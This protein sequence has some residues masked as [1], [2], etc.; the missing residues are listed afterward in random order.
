MGQFE[1]TLF[2]YFE[3]M[4]HYVRSLPINLG[5]VT[6]SGG[7]V[8]GPPGGFIGYLPQTRIAYDL[9]E[10]ETDYTPL[11]GM[12]L[13]DN[14]NHIRNRITAIEVSGGGTG[15]GH[16]IQDESVSLTQR[17]KLNFLGSSVTVV[18][19]EEDDSTDVT[20]SITGS[21]VTSNHNELDNLQG[22]T[23]NQYYHLTS[24]EHTDLTD[25]GDSSLHY[26]STDR[27][28]ANH[29]GTQDESSLALT[30]ITTNDVTTARHGF[31][32][33]LPNDATKFLDGLGDWVVIS[34]S[35]GGGHVIQ[36]ESIS[37]PQR[38]KLDFRGSVL[39]TDDEE[40]DSTIVNVTISG[41]SDTIGTMPSIDV[42]KTTVDTPDDEFNSSTLDAKW[43]VV[44]G[45]S[46]TVSN[47]STSGGIYDLA[48]VSGLLLTQTNN[49]NNVRLR[50]DYTLPDGSSIVVCC[51]FNT[52]S[53]AQSGI[54]NN[55]TQIGIMLNGDDSNP[56]SAS[57]IE[58][59]VDANAEGWRLYATNGTTSLSTPT[60]SGV[61]SAL[62]A[63]KVYLRVYRDGLDYYC[64]Y[65]Y[66]GILWSFF[67]KLTLASAADNVWIRSDSSADIDGPSP[68]NGFDW[69]RLGGSG[70]RPWEYGYVGGTSTVTV[71][72][73]SGGHIIQDNGESLEQRTYLNFTGLGITVTDSSEDDATT[74]NINASGGGG[75]I[76]INESDEEM[77]QR[78]KLKFSGD[79]IV[80]TDD[81]ENDT[82]IVEVS[83]TISGESGGHIIQDDG[84]NLPQR[85]YL[86]IYGTGV[87]VVDNESEDSTDIEITTISGGGGGHIITYSGEA[88]TT[89]T[90]LDF[91]GNVVVTDDAE[92]DATVVTISGVGGGS[93][94]QS[95][96]YIKTVFNS[97][98]QDITVNNTWTDV[99]G[100]SITLDVPEDAT[101]LLVEATVI[102]NGTS[103][104]W[105]NSY[106]RVDLDSTTQ[107]ESWGQSKSANVSTSQKFPISFHTV[108]ESV[109]AGSH[110]LKLQW[111]TSSD[112][113]VS[114]HN[115]RMTVMVCQ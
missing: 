69:I 101:S 103:S 22:G 82:T 84:D 38:S 47:T 35:T 65:S 104:N 45:T 61:T 73:E 11:S 52:T 10:D 14:L 89:R 102:W 15:G 109:S 64:S 17:T 57:R 108:F 13:L 56:L 54:L 90:N 8:G 93:S 62:I 27:N 43:T 31:I 48:T 59:I 25:A 71:S 32:P 70:I 42:E 81:S 97:T 66:D 60:G 5:G 2:S 30:D 20:I 1:D 44:A 105:E 80:V 28:R 95:Y 9:S 79:G 114:L 55:Q 99:T 23:T 88:V 49:G 68:I 24:T 18:D 74:I 33:K 111:F 115:K 21:G 41:T 85:T 19:N 39:V 100:M 7:G 86:N 4:R 36:S 34:G 107:S 67:K 96:P 63:H 58:Y 77:T 72:G 37:L 46:G 112:M 92:N 26:H 113:N 91:R 3:N 40:N 94:T 83:A 76:I 78:A 110:T 6:A 106:F 12:S 50:Q 53:D 29:T 98:Q 75:H 51:I 87:T 16:V